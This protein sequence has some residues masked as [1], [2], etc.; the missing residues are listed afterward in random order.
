LRGVEVVVNPILH[1]G[2][3][4]ELAL[5]EVVRVRGDLGED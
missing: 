2:L 1:G 5:V 4:P 3:E